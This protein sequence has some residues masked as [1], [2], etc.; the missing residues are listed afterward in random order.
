[1]RLHHNS[2]YF[3]SNPDLLVSLGVK[4]VSY[5]NIMLDQGKFS[6]GRHYHN[7]LTCKT[8]IGTCTRAYI[9]NAGGSEACCEDYRC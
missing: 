9:A 6:P 8:M 2:I 3:E 4:C 7:T 1:M 5:T